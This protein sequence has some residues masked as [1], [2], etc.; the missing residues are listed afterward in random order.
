MSDPVV[1]S[2]FEVFSAEV[3]SIEKLE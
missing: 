3:G 2:I 1:Q